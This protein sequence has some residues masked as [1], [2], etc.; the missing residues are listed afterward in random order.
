MVRFGAVLCFR[1]D[2]LDKAAGGKKK[3]MCESGKGA[4]RNGAC[5]LSCV[6]ACEASGHALADHYQSRW[7]P[8]RGFVNM[9]SRECTKSCDQPDKRVTRTS[10]QRKFDA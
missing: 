1:R 3:W 2:V 6:K 5:K 7:F 10:F 9:C 8:R 4:T